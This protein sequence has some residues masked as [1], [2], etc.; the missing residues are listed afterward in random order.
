[1]FDCILAMAFSHI[2]GMEWNSIL[3]L[4]QI[5]ILKLR[6]QLLLSCDVFQE[7]GI[8]EMEFRTQKVEYSK[9]EERHFHY[10]LQIS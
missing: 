4:R 6:C 10:Y 9:T 1:M 2:Y 8:A 7:D 5:S 3:A